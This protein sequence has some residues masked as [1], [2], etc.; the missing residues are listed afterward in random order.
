M[1]SSK[2]SGWLSSEGPEYC[3]ANFQPI[4]DCFIPNFKLKYEDSENVKAD[5][6]NTVIFDLHRIKCQ[7]F[8]LGHPVYNMFIFKGLNFFRTAILERLRSHFAKIAHKVAK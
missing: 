5:L 6:V 4:L 2:K 1:H 3:S 7:A 8:F